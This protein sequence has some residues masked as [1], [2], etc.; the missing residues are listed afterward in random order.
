MA[1]INAKIIASS[2]TKLT[3]S[4]S[5]KGGCA[6]CEKSTHCGVFFLSDDED[7]TLFVDTE[8]S[9]CQPGD[10]V[11]IVCEDSTL[12]QYISIIFI[13]TLCCLLLTTSMVDSLYSQWSL[14]LKISV[15]LFASF[16]LGALLSRKLL[17]RFTSGKSAF[18]LKKSDPQK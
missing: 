16:G 17:Q 10:D 6:N 14:G 1:E 9:Q 18:V 15:Q 11:A 3:L 5:R 4:A 12:L 2:A 7:K 8:N 13:P